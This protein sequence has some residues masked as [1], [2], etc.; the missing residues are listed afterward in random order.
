MY[1]KKWSFVSLSWIEG[2]APDN[3]KSWVEENGFVDLCEHNKKVFATSEM[4]LLIE[5]GFFQ[6][7]TQYTDGN[8]F[9]EVIGC[10]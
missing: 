8:Y 10:K 4:T 6:K 7:I 9:I 3:K 1:F 2:T 5:G